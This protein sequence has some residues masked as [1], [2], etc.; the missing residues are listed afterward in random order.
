MQ[1]TSSHWHHSR[2][3]AALGTAFLPMH[4]LLLAPPASAQEAPDLREVVGAYVKGATTHAQFEADIQRGK[5]NVGMKQIR[6]AQTLDMTWTVS[7]L[8]RVYGAKGASCSLEFKGP[9]EDKK[10]FDIGQVPL[11]SAN[12]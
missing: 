9:V 5:W 7:I 8:Y 3:R 11:L 10:T 1:R 4:L 2:L 12:C 6:S